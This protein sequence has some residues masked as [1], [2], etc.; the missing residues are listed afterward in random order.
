MKP[1]FPKSVMYKSI[2]KGRAGQPVLSLEQNARWCPESKFTIGPISR[3]LGFAI[4]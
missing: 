4:T 2:D 1:R 3:W